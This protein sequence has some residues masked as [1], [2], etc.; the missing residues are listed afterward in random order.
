MSR[1]FDL[2]SSLATECRAY[3]NNVAVKLAPDYQ[4]GEHEF[5]SQIY[6]VPTDSDREISSRADAK[7]VFTY[8]VGLLKWCRDENGLREEVENLEAMAESLLG[9]MLDNAFIARVETKALYS[10]EAY[11]K[12]K[13]YVGVL[14]VQIQ[15]LR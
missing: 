12:R 8:E 1:L 15:D 14:E 2:A 7:R 4:L 11:A 9:T 13:Q 5:T 10:V 6:I 3:A